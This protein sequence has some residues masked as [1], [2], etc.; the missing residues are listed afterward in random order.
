[1]KLGIDPAGAKI[2][3][4][5]FNKFDWPGRFM[6]GRSLD[7][8]VRNSTNWCSRRCEQTRIHLGEIIFFRKQWSFLRTN[9]VIT[10]LLFDLSTTKMSYL[11]A[12]KSKNFLMILFQFL[13]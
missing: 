1:V 5:G 2:C 7:I 10:K 4:T 9:I 12:K 13:Y 6:R 3:K 8:T 11:D